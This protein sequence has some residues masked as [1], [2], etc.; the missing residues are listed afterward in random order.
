MPTL[1]LDREVY[2]VGDPIAVTWRGGPGYRWDWIAVF[3]APAEDLV[4]TS[5]LWRH[6]L[7][8]VDG[9]VVLDADAAIVDQSS[10]GGRWPLPPGDYVA[11]YL[12]DD[13]PEAVARVPFR[14]V[15]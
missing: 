6:T 2:R 10:V 13:G 15:A 12:L 3:R 14:I 7:A 11:A 1:G 5:L 8:R 9:T 4:D